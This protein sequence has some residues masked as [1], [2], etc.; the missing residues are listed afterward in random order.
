M[1]QINV[2][3]LCHLTTLIASSDPFQGVM[4]DIGDDTPK[5]TM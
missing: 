1:G 5:G 2:T 3:P 4:L